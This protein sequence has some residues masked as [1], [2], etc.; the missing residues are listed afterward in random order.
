MSDNATVAIIPVRGNS[1]G[2]PRKNFVDFGGKPLFLWT[3]E[4][5]VESGIFDRVV[6]STEDAEIKAIFVDYILSLATRKLVDVF[7]IDRPSYLSQDHVQLDEVVLHAL[8][9]LEHN[10]DYRPETMCLLQATSPLR[11]ADHIINAFRQYSGKGTLFSA[12]VNKRYHWAVDYSV[13]PVLHNPEKRLGRQWESRQIY[14]E[15]GAI[16]IFPAKRL[17][18][19]RTL[20]LYPFDIYVMPE[21]DGW[22]IDSQWELDVA[23]LRLEKYGLHHPNMEP[24]IG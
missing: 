15:N 17:S 22:E 12:Y 23:R 10:W 11:T 18:L 9:I 16:Y 8:R 14:T 13:A 20:R 7:A 19:E 3:V 5:A 24:T 2:I 21:E 1:K 4:A 6:V